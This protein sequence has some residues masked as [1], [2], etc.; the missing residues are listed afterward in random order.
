[1]A[2]LLLDSSQ[3]FR[4]TAQRHT[5]ISDN[6]ITLLTVDH[7]HELLQG[8]HDDVFRRL[9]AAV[10]TLVSEL[11]VLRRRVVERSRQLFHMRHLHHLHLHGDPGEAL[12]VSGDGAHVLD[13]LRGAFVHAQGQVVLPR[14]KQSPRHQDLQDYCHSNYASRLRP[15]HFVSHAA[16]VIGADAWDVHKSWAKSFGAKTIGVG[17]TIERENDHIDDAE[18]CRRHAVERDAERL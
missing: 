15:H 12:P 17:E 5:R 2:R 10:Y 6:D 13:R 3:R 1:M 7:I 8:S 16:D 14:G 11:A 9:F 18:S 4:H